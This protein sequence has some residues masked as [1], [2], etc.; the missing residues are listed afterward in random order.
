MNVRF[1]PM[2]LAAVLLLTGAPVP[3]Q[4]EIGNDG[5]A[6]SSRRNSRSRT[7]NSN[8]ASP[9]SA[10]NN[11]TDFGGDSRARGRTR[12]SDQA[13]KTNQSGSR[14]TPTPAANAQ[15]SPPAAD[16]KRTVRGKQQQ[17]AAPSGGGEARAATNI[18]FKMKAND[19]T[20]V[21]YIEGMGSEPTMNIQAVEGEEFVTRV[22]LQN[23]RGTTFD[24]FRVSLKY[25]PTL[26]RP[27]GLDDRDIRSMT[28][29]PPAAQVDDRRGIISVAFDLDKPRT[30][31]ALGLFKV[32]WKA[33]APAS[34][35][36]ISFLNTEKHPTYILTP[37]GLNVLHQR[38]EDGPVEASE[39]TG[40]VDASVTIAP[41]QS[42]AK[43]LQEDNQSFSAISLAHGIAEGTAQGGVILELRPRVSTVRVGEEF[44]VDVLYSNPKRAELDTVQLS[45]RFDPAALQVVDWDE[46]NWITRGVNVY[47]G[48]YHDD[49]PFDFHRRNDA[50]NS[51]GRI[52]YDM[53]FK[54]RVRI[55]NR[56]VIGTIRMR[57]IAPTPRAEMA[58]ELTEDEEDRALTAVSFLGF[59]L[60]GAPGQRAGFLRNAA[61]AVNSL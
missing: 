23:P 13:R 43:V 60:I 2:V 15:G 56:G 54:N 35:G 22:G 61:V 33:L 41:S 10:S 55:P 49:L 26:M 32:Q 52:E 45:I 50:N 30:D 53:G 4:D 11:T 51:T 16:G 9:N 3:A 58:F 37:K 17:K 57:A 1:M 28:E 27:V 24:K 40:L 7:S 21:L 14:T 19:N 20:N 29:K 59:N 46:D 48:E 5:N 34:F 38:D 25:D 44:L 47:D 8:S 31:P 6:F 39:K 12:D 42:T 18:E 36:P